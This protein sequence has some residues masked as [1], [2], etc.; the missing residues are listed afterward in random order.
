M[1]TS[2]RSSS[3]LSRDPRRLGSFSAIVVA[4]PE[5]VQAVDGWRERTCLAKPSLG[6]PPHITVLFPFIEPERLDEAVVSELGRI[7]ARSPRFRF[8]LDT[9]GRFASTL[10]L[11]PEPADPFVRLT[12]E[13]VERYP[14]WKPYGGAFGSVVPHLTVAEGDATVLD[15]AEADVQRML[16]IE[17]EAREVLVI[18]ATHSE[19]RWNTIARLPLAGS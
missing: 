9:T 17:A 6:I 18:A 16:P 13:I 11:A 14:D 10:Y 5:V 12:S 4:V 1:R 8:A 19:T 7:T 3:G 15:L 2:G